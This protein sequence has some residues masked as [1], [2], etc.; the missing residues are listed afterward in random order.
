MKNKAR[1]R[2][3]KFVS[4][5]R[6]ASS[7]AQSASSCAIERALHQASMAWSRVAASADAMRS[8]TRG[9]ML[10]RADG[11]QF[12]DLREDAIAVA[13]RQRQ[14]QLR[15]QQTVRRADIVASAGDRK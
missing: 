10:F 11:E 7:S 3:Y 14:S 8:V 2:W 4:R 13:A 5:R 6:N 9:V 1:T 15:E 12:D